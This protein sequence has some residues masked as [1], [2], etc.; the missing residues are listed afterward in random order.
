MFQKAKLDKKNH[1]AI[2]ELLMTGTIWR[3]FIYNK[4]HFLAFS[5]FQAD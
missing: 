2:D 4:R 5:E 1:C 3:S